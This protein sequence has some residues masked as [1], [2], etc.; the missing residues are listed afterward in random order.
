MNVATSKP[1][2]EVGVREL[3][4]NLSRY[5]E[6]VGDGVEVIVTD[7]GQPIARLSGIDPATSKLAA[8][9]AAGLVQQP[10]SSDRRRPKRRIMATSSVSELVADQR[11]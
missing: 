5:L 2:L 8:L 11:R 4:N 6:R 1:E 10:T 3:K 7:R 9:V